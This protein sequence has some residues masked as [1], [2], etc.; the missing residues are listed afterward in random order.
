M[1]AAVAGCGSVPQPFL[2][3]GPS[4]NPLLAPTSQLGVLVRP[5]ADAPAARGLAEAIAEALRRRDIPAHTASAN[6]AS[7]MLAAR[8]EVAPAAGP[9]PGREVALQWFLS[10]SDRRLVGE[11]RHVAF[12]EGNAWE[13]ADSGLRGRL[14]DQAAAAVAALLTGESEP[15]AAPSPG[16]IAIAAVEGAPGDGD[17]SLRRAM[18]YE[19]RR[20]GVAVTEDRA[21]A[22]TIVR[23]AVR[24]GD[25][26]DGTET[27]EIVWTALSAEGDE[28][29]TVTQANRVPKGALARS[30]GATAI[31]AARAAAAGIARLIERAA[32][33]RPAGTGAPRPSPGPAR[34]EAGPGS[35][36]L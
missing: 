4:A 32:Q 25:A 21:A 1:I 13:R 33:A 17:I 27:V 12:A 16:G 35:K 14:A 34:S 7:Y 22:A 18:A 6:R 10:D 29:G 11:R 3:D 9:G 30:W 23:G 2:R 28:L 5:V 36:G 15:G 19:L 8:A 20:L 24:L 26:G 31:L